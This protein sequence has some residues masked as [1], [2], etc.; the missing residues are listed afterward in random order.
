MIGMSA[1]T[2]QYLSDYEHLRQS[3]VD[4]LKTPIGSR[5]M[6]RNYGSNLPFLIDRPFSP[7]LLL[8]VYK[9][10][11]EAL[12]LWE[13]RIKT[14]NIFADLVE[15]HITINIYGIYLTEGRSFSFERLTIQ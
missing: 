4:I 3:V 7:S 8:D 9:A 11:A 10:T 2:G 6:R 1:Q 14:Q 12:R 13:P 5:V 15:G